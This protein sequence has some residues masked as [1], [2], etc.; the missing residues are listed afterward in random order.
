MD[1]ESTLVSDAIGNE[2]LSYGE[3]ALISVGIL[4]DVNLD[5]EINILDVIS[6]VNFAIYIDEPNDSQFWSADLN[7]DNMLD[8]LDIVIIVNMILDN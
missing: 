8:I 1:F 2:I 4:G 7:S 5:T 6:I 3:G